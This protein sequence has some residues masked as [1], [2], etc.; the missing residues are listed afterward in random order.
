[1]IDNLL[2]LGTLP[3]QS[4]LSD[5]SAIALEWSIATVLRS[6]DELFVCSVMEAA[7][8]TDSATKDRVAKLRN[9]KERQTTAL[10]LVKQTTALLNRTQLHVTVTAQALHAKNAKHLMIDLIDHINP[11][12]V[13]M[14]SRGLG[15]LAGIVLGSTSRYLI[16]KVS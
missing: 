6:G 10:V 16:E 7:D 14:G 1:M 15:K 4:D 13:V 3:K 9:Q 5:E 11:T 8:K 2:T 12:L